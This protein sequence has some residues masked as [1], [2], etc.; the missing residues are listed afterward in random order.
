MVIEISSMKTA[1]KYYTRIT[2]QN[3]TL[4]CMSSP[5]YSSSEYDVRDLQIEHV[6]KSFSDVDA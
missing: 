6:I 3:K 4:K 5:E 1:G 2:M